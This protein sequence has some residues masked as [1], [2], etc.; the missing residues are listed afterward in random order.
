MFIFLSKIIPP[1]VYPLGFTCLLIIAAL[2][3][4]RK[5]R[6]QRFLL[7]LALCLLFLCSNRWVAWGLTRS[8]EWQHL[9][10]AQISHE[11]VIVVLGG[12][13]QSALY[14][15]QMVEVNGAGDRIIYAFWLY[16]QGKADHLLLTGGSIDW[17]SSEENP[18]TDMLSLLR[19]FGVPE[20]AIWLEPDSR[21][22]YEDA[23]YSAELL[24]ENG[25]SRIILVTSALHMPRSVALFKKQ[26]IEVIPAPAD[27]IVTQKGWD[28]LSKTNF[29]GQLF[30]LLPGAENLS[31]TSR[32]LKEYLGILVYR[33][34]GWL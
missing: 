30:N 11:D 17:L 22:T 13:T 7:I 24:K 26:G 20:E 3:F 27:F 25:I 16:Q 14:P 34:N 10:P 1:L 23:K 2:V 32:A 31:N 4:Y 18:A 15:R 19:V 33:I 9:P 6:L 12:G 8:L 28:N 29:A 5:I 21:N